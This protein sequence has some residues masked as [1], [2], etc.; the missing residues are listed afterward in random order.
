MIILFQ[1]HLSLTFFILTLITYPQ[2]YHKW[3]VLLWHVSSPLLIGIIA[4][5][6]VIFVR[7]GLTTPIAQVGDKWKRLHRAAAWVI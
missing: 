5:L 6:F 7:E 2:S 4:E 1:P 3:Q